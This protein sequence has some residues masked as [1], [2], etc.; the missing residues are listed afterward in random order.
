MM[1]LKL[2]FILT[3]TALLLF[4]MGDLMAQSSKSNSIGE[5]RVVEG[6]TAVHTAD[7]PMSLIAPGFKISVSDTVITKDEGFLSFIFNDSSIIH[8]QPGSKVSFHETDHIKQSE[9]R[10]KLHS[11]QILVEAV[12]ANQLLQV[13]TPTAVAVTGNAIYKI[14]ITENGSTAFTGIHG[15]VEI[16]AAGS[17]ETQML[18]RRNR[19]KTDLR[20]QFFTVQQIS[21]REVDNVRN[22]FSRFSTTKDANPGQ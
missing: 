11:G 20:G 21:N 14:E 5:I 15:S 9:I 8:L 12:Q 4:L 3:A 19:L 16:T 22:S 2:T 6:L 17:G 1:N 10:I 7:G 13:I 18:A